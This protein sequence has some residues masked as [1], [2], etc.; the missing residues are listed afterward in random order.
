MFLHKFSIAGYDTAEVL[1]PGSILSR[2]QNRMS[3]PL[4]AH[5]L[6]L[7]GES[8]EG[9]GLA[10]NEK[11]HRVRVLLPCDPLDVLAGIDADIGEHA[12]EQ[13]MVTPSEHIK[14]NGLSLQITR[15]LDALGCKELIATRMDSSEHD[16]RLPG[17]QGWQVAWRVPHRRVCPTCGDSIWPGCAPHFDVLHFGESFQA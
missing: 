13:N 4:R 16:D 9:V 14:G 7:W 6:R 2:I 10:F 15:R 17:V 8:H 3:D 5:F 11:A 1:R 12:G